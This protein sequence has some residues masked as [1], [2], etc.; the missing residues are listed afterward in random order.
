LIVSGAEICFRDVTKNFQDREAVLAG[1][2]FDVT[3]GSFV[4]LLGPSGCGK[5]TALRIMAGLEQ[6]SG[7]LARI[8]P[9]GT[10]CGFVFQDAS[11][12]PW[13]SVRANVSIGL[14]LRGDAGGLIADRVHEA[15]DLVGLSDAADLMPHELSGGM[16][17]RASLAR[18][19]VVRPDL[20]LLDE[21]FAALDEETR[22]DL[23]Y[24]M[25]KL[26]LKLKTTVIFVTHAVSEALFLSER[27]LVLSKK[28]ARIIM[29]YQ[30]GLSADRPRSLHS[31]IRFSEE[32]IHF[33]DRL[34]GVGR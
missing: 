18:A 31:D 14:E 23:Q 5:S 12:M 20:L 28:P 4:A 15:L 30:V 21:P 2:S 26:W 19:L 11:L 27:V 32:I 3:A 33:H 22:H 34:R 1:I 29:D 16:K 9:A 24:E 17:M 13:R 8:S 10:P 25:R 7:G 6:P